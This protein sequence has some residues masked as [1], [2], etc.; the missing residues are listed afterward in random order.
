VTGC[1]VSAPLMG[2]VDSYD[3]V[4]TDAANRKFGHDVFKDAWDEAQREVGSKPTRE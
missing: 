2:Y 1:I 4:S 3:A